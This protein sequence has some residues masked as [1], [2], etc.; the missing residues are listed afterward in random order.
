VTAALRVKVKGDGSGVTSGLV[1]QWEEAHRAEEEG[2]CTLG[3]PS[4]LIRS[5][6]PEVFF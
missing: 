3:G 4:A 2:C 1:M 6:T 5:S